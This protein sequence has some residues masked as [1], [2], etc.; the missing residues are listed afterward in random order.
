[1]ANNVSII[2]NSVTKARNTSAKQPGGPTMGGVQGVG[3]ATTP[4]RPTSSRKPSIVTAHH[5]G[6]TTFGEERTV[7]GSYDDWKKELPH[8]LSHIDSTS[9]KHVSTAKKKGGDGKMYNVGVYHHQ[10]GAGQVYEGKIVGHDWEDIQ[11]AQQGGSLHKKV[12]MSK[13]IGPSPAT[14]ADH[15]LHKQ[16]GS[17]K[18]LENA[19]LHGVVDRLKGSGITE[20]KESE[21]TANQLLGQTSRMKLIKA[22]YKPKHTAGGMNDYYAH[23]AKATSVKEE[24][25]IGDDVLVEQVEAGDHVKFGGNTPKS[26]VKGKVVKCDGDYHQVKLAT[27]GQVWVHKSLLKKYALREAQSVNEDAP[28]MSVANGSVAGVAPP[29]ATV[30]YAAQKLKKIKQMAMAKRKAPKGE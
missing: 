9:E 28:A 20:G 16:H 10:A 22:Y 23:N 14:Q 4:K 26:G 13:P 6:P 12:D 24:L 1:M 19:G 25:E 17:L 15:D 8:D 27:G 7:Y 29:D 11:R 21:H 3:A 5:T 30:D 18:A 2:K